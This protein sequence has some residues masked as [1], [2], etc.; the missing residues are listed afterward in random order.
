MDWKLFN[1]LGS[2]A[3]FALVFVWTFT[4]RADLA[5]LNG[6]ASILSAIWYIAP[7]EPTSQK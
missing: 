2:L 4:D 3:N 5:T 6:V 7:Q 1:L